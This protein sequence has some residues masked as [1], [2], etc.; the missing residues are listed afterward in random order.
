MD[1]RGVSRIQPARVVIDSWQ[2]AGLVERLVAMQMR[3]EEVKLSEPIVGRIGTSCTWPS[4]STGC[5][6]RQTRSFS[7][8]C[9]R[10]VLRKTNFGDFRLDHDSSKHDDQAMAIGLAVVELAG[11][12][13]RSGAV[14]VLFTPEDIMRQDLA[15]ARAMGTVPEPVKLLGRAVRRR[16]LDA[17][18]RSPR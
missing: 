7:R 16:Y 18:G 9:G 8:S 13:Q 3:A 15:E 17:R 11:P 10:F 6:S 5:R 14:P 4:G 1:R 2:A 12:V